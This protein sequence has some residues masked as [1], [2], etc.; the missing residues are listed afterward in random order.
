MNWVWDHSRSRHGARLVLLAIAD[1]ARDDGTAWPSVTE[2]KRKTGLG[3]RAVQAAIIDCHKLGE[4]DVG[5]QEGPKGCN[6]YRITM[7]RPPADIAPPPQILRGADIAGPPQDLRGSDVSS[8]VN[9]QY[10]AESAPPADIA[11]TPADICA[12]PADFDADP[13]RICGRNH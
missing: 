6:R 13:R 5:Y 11:G 7:T 4:L 12:P 8:Q 9:G 2:I 3:D 10:P 1:C